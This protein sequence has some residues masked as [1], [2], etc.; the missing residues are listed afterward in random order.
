L[1]ISR[2][3]RVH[4]EPQPNFMIFP[5][6]I[7]LLAGPPAGLKEAEILLN[8]L[9][10]QEDEEDTDRFETAEIK[11]SED[12]DLSGKSSADLHFRQKFGVTLV[13]IRRGHEQITTISPAEHLRGGDC[14]IVIGKA[15]AIKEL[16]NLAPL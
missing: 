5:A 9:G 12:S 4:Y 10:V 16:K 13:G 6:D 2:G 15:G 7:L 3:G 1:A 11:V 14:L 8:Q